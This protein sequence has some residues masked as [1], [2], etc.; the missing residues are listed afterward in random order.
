[1]TNGFL[2]LLVQFYLCQPCM[3]AVI[4][5]VAF[6]GF[7]ICICRQVE[8][9]I[10][11]PTPTDKTQ[12]SASFPAHLECL[13]DFSNLGDR[14]SPF[15]LFQ[16]VLCH[17]VNRPQLKKNTLLFMDI[18]LFQSSDVTDNSVIMNP[19][20]VSPRTLV[21]LAADIPERLSACTEVVR[22]RSLD[23]RPRHSPQEVCQLGSRQ[24]DVR[25]PVSQPRPPY[26]SERRGRA[27]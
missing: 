11:I 12:R 6:Q 2:G 1:M 24:R 27:P 23:T 8:M 14:A 25:V 10:L 19:V 26:V 20:C 21:S 9:H 22:T 16:Y 17:G 4:S 3:G 15:S 18:G 5:C 13:A 7:F